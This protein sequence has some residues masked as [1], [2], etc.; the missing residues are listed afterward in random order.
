MGLPV[1]PGDFLALMDALVVTDSDSIPPTQNDAIFQWTKHAIE[2][3][4][5]QTAVNSLLATL[6]DGM[7][8]CR[9][10]IPC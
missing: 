10:K 3:Q 7:R 8:N 1:S 9:G 4:G 2:E 6:Q 5:N